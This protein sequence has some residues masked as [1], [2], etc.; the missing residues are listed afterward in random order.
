MTFGI[1]G[2]E[3]VRDVK[4]S[5]GVDLLLAP[6][7]H[8]LDALLADAARDAG[9]DL[10]SGLS[11]TGVRRDG[12]GRV[13][14]VTVKDRDGGSS[15]LNARYVIGADGRHSTVARIVGADTIESFTSDAGLFY[16]YVASPA[17]DGF[18][19][20]LAPSSFAGVFPTHAG[21]ACVWLCR[22]MPLLDG[23]RQ[24]G[25]QRG[26]A[27]LDQLEHVA[28]SVA[29]RSRA[30]ML[31][32]SV[33]GVSRMPNYVRRAYGPGWALV[34]DAGYH[35]D[36]ITGHGIT[37]A[38]RDAELLAGAVSAALRDSTDDALAGYVTARDAALREVLDI[39][40]ALTT[41]PEQHRF[42]ELQ[43]QLSSALDRE[44][45]ML[46]SLPAWSGDRAAA[47]AA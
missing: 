27:L 28:P 47:T 32:G 26:A 4:D 22:P 14:G 39:T 25:V 31:V 37:D 7:R 12:S 29:E 43:I 21:Q 18:E 46:A 20:H 5:A 11:A 13:L 36:P 41:F 1:L 16:A 17:W 45:Q 34:G 6:R 3:T 24:A 40:R 2:E 30:G 8:V 19:F 10:R 42:A 33:R 38:F 15:E 35:R 23:I 44:A 9:A